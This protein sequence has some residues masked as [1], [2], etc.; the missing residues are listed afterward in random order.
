MSWKQRAVVAGS[1]DLYQI[2][3]RP[4]GGMTIIALRFDAWGGP[5]VARGLKGLGGSVSWAFGGSQGFEI[6]HNLPALRFRQLR[7]HGHAASNH[8]VGE[9]PKQRAGGRALHFLRPQARTFAAAFSGL[10]VAL[11]TVLGKQ[12]C[13][14]RHCIG[15]PFQR[16]APLNCFL[17]GFRQLGVNG[18]VLGWSCGI[19]LLR[20]SCGN[21]ESQGQS[22]CNGERVFCLP[23]YYYYC[24]WLPPSNRRPMA[25]P[26][27]ENSRETPQRNRKRWLLSFRPNP[28]DRRRVQFDGRFHPTTGAR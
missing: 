21:S 22:R 20:P 5:K 8:T 2:S 26:N 14:C 4:I 11:D 9:N 15:I 13:A 23:H 18:I 12:V 24:D 7:P 17:R 25:A 3:A 10:A 28:G 1:C 16:V 27:P 6:A 19:F